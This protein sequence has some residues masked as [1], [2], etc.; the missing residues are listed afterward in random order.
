MIRSISIRPAL[1]ALLALI[2]LHASCAL[3]EAQQRGPATDPVTVALLPQAVSD[4]DLVC[5][6]QIAKLSGGSEAARARIGRL[7]IVGFKLGPSPGGV[8]QEQVRFRLLL[9][10]IDEARFNLQGSKRTVIVESDE[11]VTQRTVLAA[12]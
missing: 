4:D 8:A 12:A 3:A 6:G 11:P 5:L 7:D 1:L 9:A 2:A 10:G